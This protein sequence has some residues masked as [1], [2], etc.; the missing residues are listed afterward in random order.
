ME[1]KKGCQVVSAILI[2]ETESGAG[3][4]QATIKYSS[5]EGNTQT[6]SDKNIGL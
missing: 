1:V 4:T 3:H 5:Q 6:Q 2:F